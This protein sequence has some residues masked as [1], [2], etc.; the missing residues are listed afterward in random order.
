MSNVSNMSLD[1]AV[2]GQ[3][4]VNHS[5]NTHTHLSI[6]AEI[7]TDTPA[8]HS[9][10]L[11]H[12]WMLSHKHLSITAEHSR[13]CQSQPKYSH[14]PANCREIPTDHSPI[15]TRNCQSQPKYAHTPVNLSWIF[16]DTPANHSL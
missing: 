1:D 9:L 6:T 3:A 15:L 7:L 14:I 4:P 2:H 16:M 11:N 8:N 13:T 5:Q 10:I 12:S